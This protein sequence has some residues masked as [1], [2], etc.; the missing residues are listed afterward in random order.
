MSQSASEQTSSSEV[1][2]VHALYSSQVP[3][4]SEKK[5]VDLD[6]GNLRSSEE[7]LNY[8]FRQESHHDSLK[9]WF[10]ES[11]KYDATI[12]HRFESTMY[13]AD[14]GLLK[15]WLRTRRG[16][17]AFV[18]LTDQMACQILGEECGLALE[19]FRK[20]SLTVTKHCVKNY[21]LEQFTS[22]E[23]LFL[24]FPYRYSKDV[25][26]QEKGVSLL[27]SILKLRPE[28]RIL[29]KTLEYQK[30]QRNTIR[31][32]S[33]QMFYVQQLKTKGV[34]LT[35]FLHLGGKLGKSEVKHQ[36]NMAKL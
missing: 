32:W 15:R 4:A 21:G 14:A 28:D 29:L 23:I 36:Q 17:L 22:E 7:V 27:N 12:K 26:D 5:I 1:T 10:T 34:D 30:K 20:L 25:R 6:V 33:E 16:C 8:W 11:K 24:L 9:R 18:I 13:A 31:T 3:P 19:Q 2:P 35:Y